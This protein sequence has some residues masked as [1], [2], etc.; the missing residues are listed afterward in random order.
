LF[1]S[2]RSHGSL[3]SG[4]PRSVCGAELV[5]LALGL[6]ELIFSSAK[7]TRQILI[8]LLDLIEAPLLVAIL[9]GDGLTELFQLL[10]GRIRR[11][12][13]GCGLRARVG[14]LGKGIRR[15]RRIA[16]Q[17]EHQQA[18]QPILLHVLLPFLCRWKRCGPGAG[19]C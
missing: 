12:N 11:R 19:L 15:D 8:L 14:R 10:A 2:E 1:G 9:L 5:D 6:G 3:E 13:G 18:G 7:L 4:D 16:N 17:G